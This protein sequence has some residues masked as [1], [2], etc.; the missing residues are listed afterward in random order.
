MLGLLEDGRDRGVL[1]HLTQVH[2]QH[3]VAQ[4]AHHAQVVG[5]PQDRHAQLVAAFFHQV[6]DLRLHGDVERGRRFVRDQQAGVAHHGHGQHHALAHAAGE[7]VGV[8]VDHLFG[9]RHVDAAQRRDRHLPRGVLGDRLVV[10][11]GLHDLKADRVRG[12]E[13]GHRLLEHHGHVAAADGAHL[14]AVEA[15]GGDVGGAAVLVVEPDVA[16]ADAPVGTG[17]Q[18]HD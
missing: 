4:L 2:H 9:I 12:V 6:Q 13:R 7:L 15:Q 3:A 11:D 17:H 10:E 14:A 5:D 18:A 1:D 8:A 16:A